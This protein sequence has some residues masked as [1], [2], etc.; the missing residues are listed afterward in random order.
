MNRFGHSRV[1]PLRSRSR[2]R[3]D[4]P[5]G[6]SCRHREQPRRHGRDEYF[7]LFEQSP[8]AI[9]LTRPDGTILRANPAA[10]RMFAMTEGEVCRAGRAGIVDASDGRLAAAL[11]ERSRAGGMSAELTCVRKG[12]ERFPGQ[13]SSVIVPGEP[14]QAFVFVRDLTAHRRLEDSLSE[15]E[16]RFRN[17]AE[18]ELMEARTRA[19]LKAAEAAVIM[20]AMPAAVFVA[21]DVTCTHMTGNA[22][23]QDLLGLPATANFSKSAP[24]DQRPM[25]FRAMRD[26][27]EIPV[28]QLPVQR[29]ARGNPVRDYEFKIV[30]DDGRERTL[31]GDAVPLL[32]AEGRPRGAVGVFRDITARKQ[33][34]ESLRQ[35]EQLYRAIGE[36]IDYGVWTCGPDGRNTYASESFLKMVGMTQDQCSN[37]GW[38]AVL[39]PDDSERTIARWQEC[40][41]TG[42]AWDIEH[43]F[44]GVDGQ[45]HHVLA[46]GVPVLDAEGRVSCWAG[47]NLDID[48]LKQMETTLKTEARRKDDF[49]ALLGHELRNPLAPIRNAVYLLRNGGQNPELL[50]SACAIVERQV[51]H[52]VRLVDD[53]LDLSRITQGK[54]QLKKEAFELTEAVRGILAD[55]QPVLDQNGLGL[56]ASLAEGLILVEADR[57]RIVQAVSNLLHNAIKFTDFGGRILVAVGADEGGRAYVRV[58]DSGTG[59]SSDALPTIFEPFMQSKETIGRTR[60]GLGLGLALTKGLIEL[61]GGTVSADSGGPGL[62]SEFTLRMPRIGIPGAAGAEG[63]PAPPR[64]TRRSRRILVVEDI[65]DAATS[66][67]MLLQLLGH[68]VAIAQDGKAALD[69]ADRF[70]PEII[71]CDIGLPGGINGYEVARTLRRSPRLKHMHLI[72]MTGFGTQEDKD[73]AAEAGFDAHLTKPVDP[74]ILEPLIANLPI[75]G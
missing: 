28:E 41:R 52:L 5:R 55:Y 23:C 2:E 40:V 20:D 38:G 17:L 69:A 31:L 26:G 67:Q 8:D 11:A 34:E 65:L 10:C 58:K 56:E 66:L 70:G 73:R 62:G 68:T 35:S 47:I 15:S 14:P 29:A 57:A 44:R 19:E 21:H 45:W 37:F 27:R 48:R 9:L 54:V 64:E 1:Q 30:F 7:A 42:G 33:M 36:S 49:L 72:A 12:G 46:R 71:L 59:I 75:R 61:Q 4:R 6:R 39:H 18:V 25:H 51:T 63:R 13:V 50:D 24:L 16:V 3:L 60:G 22:M 32:D 43:R 74:E 53:L